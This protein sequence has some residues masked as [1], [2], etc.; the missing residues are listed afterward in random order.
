MLLGIL[1]QTLMISSFVFI[2]ML[3]IEYINVQTQGRFQDLIKKSRFRQYFLS[4]FLGALP[5]CLGAFTVVSLYS[6]KVLSF[7]SLVA[8]MIATSG[9]EAF[10]MFSMFPLRAFGLTA[11]LFLVGIATGYLTDLVYRKQ[12][13]LIEHVEHKYPVH[14]EDNCHCFPKDKI[15]YQI[16]H[17]TF[18][19]ALLIGI[20]TLFLL[21][22]YIDTRNGRFWDWQRITFAAGALFS[23][24]VV[25]TVP[26]HF[27]EKHLWEH[28]VKKHLPRIFLWTFG[29]LWVIHLMNNYLD[30]ESWIRDKYIFVLLIVIL[31]GV[32]PE[33]GP[34]LVLVTMYASGLLPFS[35][36][37]ANSIVQDG[38]GMLPMLAVSRRGFVLVKLINVAVG[39][40]MGLLGFLIF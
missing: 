29:A 34:H 11:I 25:G 20:F 9:D 32:I 24:F 15:W 22:L 2:M 23:L 31:I 6:H 17:I 3:L 5:G 30:V 1:R 38:H 7:G 19:R 12:D 36:L 14:E 39:L 28:V 27:L 26:D 37:L 4:V 40:T 21:F 16:K 10:V 35:I 18:P 8:T 33:S 13:Q